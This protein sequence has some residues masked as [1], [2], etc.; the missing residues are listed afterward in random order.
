MLILQSV[1]K[2]S[3]K[4]ASTRLLRKAKRNKAVS[5]KRNQSIKRLTTLP[6]IKKVDV[7]EIKKSF[8]AP[9]EA[10]PKKASKKEVEEVVE[11]TAKEEASE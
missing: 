1:S 2:K 8:G 4:M 7:E 9:A 11:N 5:R 6:V 3:V 10:K